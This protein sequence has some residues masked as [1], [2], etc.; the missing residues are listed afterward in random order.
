MIDINID[1]GIVASLE[2]T[3]NNIDKIKKI[4]GIKPVFIHNIVGFPLD[5]D[6]RCECFDI[7]I[8]DLLTGLKN[9][10]EFKLKAMN[11]AELND[12][13]ENPNLRRKI[14]YLD[15][16]NNEDKVLISEYKENESIYNN[17][18]ANQLIFDF[19]YK[20]SN[21]DA[22]FDSNEKRSYDRVCNVTSFTKNI[23]EC[24][25][26]FTEIGINDNQL[27]IS[28]YNVLDI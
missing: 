3:F 18:D 25:D 7:G 6:E 1:L 26:Y 23:K 8:L 14:E 19:F 24:V 22:N 5:Y 20:F 12:D 11:I 28:N 9:E 15:Q 2:L 27:T 16:N 4:F 13:Y 10:E 21:L 17:F